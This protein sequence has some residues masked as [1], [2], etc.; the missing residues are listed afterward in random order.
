[1]QNVHAKII[2]E[3]F[4]FRADDKLELRHT[5]EGHALGV[6]S[7]DINLQGTSILTQN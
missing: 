4:S 6:V 7:V 5:L 3:Y 2:V 1:M